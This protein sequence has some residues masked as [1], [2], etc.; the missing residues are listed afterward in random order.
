MGGRKEVLLYS[1]YV[2]G[3]AL[4][5]FTSVFQLGYS[6]ADVKK[7]MV[8]YSFLSLKWVLLV[9]FSLQKKKGGTWLRQFYFQ[10]A[11]DWSELPQWCLFLPLTLKQLCDLSKPWF[12]HLSVG[13][14]FFLRSLR[15][16][17]IT[18][19]FPNLPDQKSHPNVF[20]KILGPIPE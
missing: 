9:S 19:Y 11:R 3:A 2:P 17:G 13:G 1:Y 18:H 7:R 5:V 12:L 15:F 16:P 10:A 6:K 14:S 8:C 20:I 4:Q